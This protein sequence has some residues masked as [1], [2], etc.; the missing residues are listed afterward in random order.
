MIDNVSYPQDSNTISVEWSL[1]WGPTTIKSISMIFEVL[2]E[3]GI[4]SKQKW[5]SE[6]LLGSYP[7]WIDSVELSSKK[8]KSITSKVAPKELPYTYFLNKSYEDIFDTSN[9]VRFR[10]E[11]NVFRIADL[12]EAL[13]RSIIKGKTLLRVKDHSINFQLNL[14]WDSVDEK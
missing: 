5:D 12:D 7:C 2:S 3:N 1:Y 9:D 8:Q 6:Q 13:S 11:D 4:V 14:K 10:I